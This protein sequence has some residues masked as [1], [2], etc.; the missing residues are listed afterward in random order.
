MAAG[1]SY[2]LGANVLVHCSS[3]ERSHAAEGARGP[4]RHVKL[5][6]WLHGFRSILCNGANCTFHAASC[7]KFGPSVRAMPCSACTAGR[8][9]PDLFF[10]LRSDG[11]RD[12]MEERRFAVG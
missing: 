10:G 5:A 7:S 6:I 3:M 4:A 9:L 2:S 1:A 8:A 11:N 12:K